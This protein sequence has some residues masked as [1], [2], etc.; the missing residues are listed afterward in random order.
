MVGSRFGGMLSFELR[1]GCAIGQ[2]LG[3]LKL[4]TI[5]VSL[6]DTA[7]LIWPIAGTNLIRLSVG[8]VV[9]QASYAG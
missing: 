2:F 9:R 8:L 1:D 4:P 3:A 6:G 7:T 5:A